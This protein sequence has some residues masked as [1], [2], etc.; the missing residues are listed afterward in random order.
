MKYP[1]AGSMPRPRRAPD[2]IDTGDNM[3][4]PEQI[5]RQLVSTYHTTDPLQLIAVLHIAYLE[6]P[7]PKAVSGFTCE[8]DGHIGIVV[9]SL[10]DPEDRQTSRARELGRVLIRAQE[11][12]PSYVCEDAHTLQGLVFA[13]E[14]VALSRSTSE[15]GPSA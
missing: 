8:F 11:P 10:I 2:I 5:A 15:E 14:L 7:L 1:C 9:N 13:A 4:T 3:P 6:V 12:S